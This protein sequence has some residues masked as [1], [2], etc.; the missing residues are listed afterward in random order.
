[1]KTII[2]IPARGGSQGVPR[3]NV[4]LL[5]GKPLIEYTIQ[6][7]KSLDV[8]CYVITDDD[9]ISYI[10]NRAGVKVM[11]EPKTTGKATLDDVTIRFLGMLETKPSDDTVIILVQPTCPFVK[12][13][14]IQKAIDSIRSNNGSV[15][16]VMDDRHLAWGIDADGK[17]QKKYKERVNRQFLPADYRES[18]AVI[19]STVGNV[20]KH[21]TRI[22]EPIS[23]I[24]ITKEEGIDIDDFYDWSLAE[25]V[26]GRK[27]I[28][29]RADTHSKLGMGHVYR[30]LALA[31][32]LAQHDVTFYTA[33]EHE[34]GKEFF[35][36]YPF[37]L[38]SEAADQFANYVKKEKPDL[39]ILDVLDTQ[40]A[41]LQSLR[42]HTKKIVSFED[43]GPGATHAD[44]VINDLYQNSRIPTEKQLTG[45]E[46]SVL[47]PAFD[48]LD[49]KK[50]I[51]ANVENLLI[52]FGGTD[53]SNLTEKA[54]TALKI[55]KFGGNVTVIQGLG[56]KD[57][58]INLADYNLK[59]DVLTNVDYIA[60][61]MLKADMAISSAGRTISELVS[62]GVPTICLC[63]NPKEMLHTHASQQYGIMNLGL[64]SLIQTETL[65]AQIDFFIKN[66]ELRQKFFERQTIH[67]KTRKNRTI[68]EK[69]INL[70]K[71]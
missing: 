42:P 45:M 4:R 31:Q 37:K 24:P 15:I 70:L 20:F 44:L 69:I 9:E 19:G 57:R 71:L 5:H 43:L 61:H 16:T 14:T 3:K 7:V 21:K 40:E 52:L 46:H 27:K 53:P 34:L 63:Q 13:E 25:Y 38:V 12:P 8:D 30:T 11:R 56:R 49:I 51:K 17:P 48:I 26:V 39:V 64:G 23:L 62:L 47:A 60:A 36:K 29:L 50:E 59:G 10:A 54:L 2:L 35:S 22:V 67:S 32:E 33:S 18:G 6:S 55:A 41:F 68:V 28:I 65:A 1:M 58:V 66:S